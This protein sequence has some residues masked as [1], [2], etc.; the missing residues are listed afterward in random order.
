[1]L[2]FQRKSINM[3]LR[4]FLRGSELLDYEW[5]ELDAMIELVVCDLDGTLLDRDEL[6]P[7]EAIAMARAL[8]QK[9]IGFTIA[10]G[11]T[12]EMAEAYVDALQLDIPYILSNG[13]TIK[14]KDTVYQRNTV[15]LRGLKALMEEADTLGMSL[16]YTV[17]GKEW[18]YKKTPWI[19]SQQLAFD[20]YHN[21]HFPTASEFETLQIDKLMV[22]DDIRE[23]AIAG[24]EKLCLGLPAEYGYT[25]YTDKSVE[26]VHAASTKGSALKILANLLN[27]EAD[28]ILVVGDH[29]NDVE[30]LEYAGVG[31]VVA[32]GI[33]E[34][35]AVADYI[36][37]SCCIKGAL[38]G[39][40][41]YC[42][43]QLN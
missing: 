20:R 40:V 13:V 24:I 31:V 34:A 41:K 37:D 16:V 15:P 38:E 32:N 7:E 19:E 25:R 30:M 36:A 6:L 4:Y 2:L 12:E 14:D 10:T 8:K 11:R 17:Q 9:G 27:I 42:N 33:P 23:G 21:I 5:K 26:V 3:A 39:V 28:R 43:I 22:M 35:K 1:M 18:V 29:Q